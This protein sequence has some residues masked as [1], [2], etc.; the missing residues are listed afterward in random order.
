L[1]LV[2]DA[3]VVDDV[4][5]VVVGVDVRRLLDGI[6]LVFLIVLRVRFALAKQL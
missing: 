2:V 4:D 5:V 1:A 6:G 3:I